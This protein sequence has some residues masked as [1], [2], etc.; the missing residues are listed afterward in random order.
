MSDQRVETKQEQGNPF[1]RKQ[2]MGAHVNHGTVHIEQSRAVTEAQGKLLLAK[3]FPRD[4]AAAYRQIMESCSRPALAACGEYAYPRGGQTV[5]GPSIRLAEELARCWGNID[6]GI[7]ELSRTDG[8]SEME[9]YAWDL[10]TNTI[11]SQ[12]FTVRHIRDKRGGG[13]ALSDERDIYEIT[14]NMGGRRLRARLMAILP[15]DLVDAAVERCRMTMA[16][17]SEEPIKDRVRKMLTAFSRFGVNERHITR[18]LDKSLDEVLP[19]DIADLQGVYNS[20][21]NGQASAG[22][23]FAMGANREARSVGN[24]LGNEDRQQ[25]QQ[26]N[27]Q[28]SAEGAFGGEQ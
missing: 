9:A 10:Q 14:A 23:F 7:R 22:D 1:A 13:Q 27:E 21:K 20:L 4:E 24:M 17:N 11:S 25:D 28:P 26:Q 6:Y 12:K 3:K 5:R 2:E 19:E 15:P 8:V 18:Y 16:G